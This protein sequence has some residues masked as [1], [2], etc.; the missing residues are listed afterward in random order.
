M[1]EHVARRVLRFGRTVGVEEEQVA[2]VH[3]RGALLVAMACQHADRQA[4]G[5]HRLHGV[6]LRVQQ[7]L[8]VVAG[9]HVAQQPAHGIE[10]GDEQRQVH[11]ARR[12]LGHVA[13]EGIDERRQ[14]EFERKP[15]AQRGLDVRHEQRRA[16]SLA[17]H[18][19]HQQRNRSAWQAEVVEK[20]AADLARGNGHAS[21]LGES[22]PQRFAR[23]HVHLNLAAQLQ[24]PA[25][26]LPFHDDLLVGFEFAG[27]LI[28]RV[29]EFAH[30]VAGRDRH[31]RA[32][33]AARQPLHA[34][35]QRRDMAGEAARQ[36]QDHGEGRD[37]QQEA[38]PEVAQRRAP[39][40]AQRRGER[41]R[42]SEDD[43]RLVV[44]RDDHPVAH[45]P[46][47]LAGQRRQLP[48]VQAESFNQFRVF[49]AHR[50]DLVVDVQDEGH[51]AAF[52]PGEAEYGL[53]HPVPVDLSV[54]LAHDG[55]VHLDRE[56]DGLAGGQCLKPLLLLG[57]TFHA[58]G[59]PGRIGARHRASVSGGRTSPQAIGF[60]LLLHGAAPGF[61]V[62]AAGSGKRHDV[63]PGP[64]AG[65]RHRAGRSPWRARLGR[66]DVHDDP[67]RTSGVPRREPALRG[68]SPRRTGQRGCPAPRPLK[69]GPGLGVGLRCRRRWRR[70]GLELQ[71]LDHGRRLGERLVDLGLQL[72]EQPG[73]LARVRFAF[74]RFHRCGRGPGRDRAR[75]VG[76]GTCRTGLPDALD[77][78]AEIRQH[79]R[80]PFAHLHRHL[81]RL[82][83]RRP[84][85][86][87]G[88]RI[89][90]VGRDH[91]QRQHGDQEKRE[92][93]PVSD[94][95]RGT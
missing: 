73:V 31:A 43:P 44:A 67:G 68:R 59:L 20:V 4:R 51:F 7:V 17:G 75:R 50:V 3:A 48:A 25:Q 65:A 22:H 8:R 87:G 15:C 71:P 94:A 95:H 78:V 5:P 16:N 2:W 6:A 90:R 45:R 93:Q 85:E 86:R 92:G 60:H 38:N 24:F 74:G 52:A 83:G 70:R 66:P 40:V 91:G 33:F 41:A 18:V 89:V 39:H 36:G 63:H 58:R 10:D 61:D 11:L 56:L 80:H 49:R 47:C 81:I 23:Q 1:A 13:I 29:R 12:V 69:A 37:N 14:V 42:N 76:G 53:D 54:D 79:E 82:F 26:A 28:E 19:A 55:A 62:L 57:A 34:I 84:P 35:R 27:H 46:G 21:D 32:A 72:G 64:R 77:A 9:V 30:L 88:G